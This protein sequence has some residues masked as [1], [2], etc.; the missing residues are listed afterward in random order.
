M[1]HDFVLI[2]VDQGGSEAGP[3]TDHVKSVSSSDQMTIGL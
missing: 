3:D 1:G 2:A